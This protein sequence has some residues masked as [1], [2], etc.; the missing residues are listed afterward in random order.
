MRVGRSYVR[1]QVG[2]TW[3]AI[4]IGSGIG[5]LTTAGFLAREGKDVLVLERHT[6]AGGCTQVFRRAGYERDMGVHYLGEVHKPTSSLFQIFDHVSGGALQWAP[7]S[8]VYNRVVIGDREYEFPSGFDSFIQR[9]KGYFPHEAAAIDAYVGLVL[10]V[11]MAARKYFGHR[12]LPPPLAAD[13]YERMCEPFLEFS[14]RTALSV[15]SELTSDKE[16]IAVLCGHF[17]D[18]S[19]SPSRVSFAMHALMVRHYMDGANYP[20][21]GSGKIAH[22]IAEVIR[23]AGGEVLIGAEVASILIGRDGTAQGVMMADGR[24]FHAPVVISDAGIANTV[25]LLPQAT[26]DRTGLSGPVAAMEPSLPW[27]LLTIGVHESSGALGL[28]R[29]NVW[30]HSD[31]DFE[32][33]MAAFDADPQHQPMPVCFLTFPSAKDPS[34]D[35]RHPG[36]AT[37]EIAGLTTWSLFEPF[38][39]SR[40][41][42]R[43]EEYDQ[44]KKRLTTELLDHVLRLFPQLDGKIDHLEL[45]TPLSFNHFLTRSAGDFLSFAHTP[46]RFRQ[47]WISAHSPVGGLFFTGQDV[48]TGGIGGAAT[49]GALTASA[50]LGRD[51]LRQLPL[52]R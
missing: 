43:G 27:V 24:S 13:A 17:G 26:A 30:V 33:R 5:G 49:A 22:S 9:M 16:L 12:A 46:Q 32:A 34:W 1:S 10:Q 40:W 50:V 48:V 29:S 39:D 44:L 18:Y 28:D 42:R 41:M 38:A 11:A 15:L 3:D 47:R 2:D 23:S 35:R 21:G 52:P 31:T 20:V 36:R 6:T 19:L 45:A 51:V 7:M 14:D 8:D 37:I 25:R 4:V